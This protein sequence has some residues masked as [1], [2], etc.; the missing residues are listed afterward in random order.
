MVS[1]IEEDLT[2]EL[3]MTEGTG[4]RVNSYEFVRGREQL[5][6]THD[7]C[8]GAMHVVLGSMSTDK[9]CANLWRNIIVKGLASGWT[10]M[11]SLVTGNNC[12]QHMVYVRGPC[13]SFLGSTSA[14]KSCAKSMEKYN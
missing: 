1:S 8:Q 5:I 7:L 12:S 4:K 13:M 6:S 2:L 10:H 14:D 3:E 9:S 11:I